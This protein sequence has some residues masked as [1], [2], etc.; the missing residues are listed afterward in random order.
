MRFVKWY[1]TTCLPMYFINTCCKHLMV[2]KQ[3]LIHKTMI[4]LIRLDDIIKLFIGSSKQ[5]EMKLLV[6][7]IEIESIRLTCITQSIEISKL[8][9]I[10]L[11]SWTEIFALKCI[12]QSENTF[13][14]MFAKQYKITNLT[15]GV[16]FI[17]SISIALLAR[18][19]CMRQS[20]NQQMVCIPHE[21]NKFLYAWE[22]RIK[23]Q[24]K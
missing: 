6:I 10:C 24:Y 2:F 5:L 19:V 11:L 21:H 17:W 8:C 14:N 15:Y 12:V 9:I 20:I 18:N 1:S 4:L 22:W 16:Q 3:I 23:A 7:Q 13:T